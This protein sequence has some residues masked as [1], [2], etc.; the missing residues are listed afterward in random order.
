MRPGAVMWGLATLVAAA[1]CSSPTAPTADAGILD[2]TRVTYSA[3]IGSGAA[4][5]RAF[6]AR[7]AGT[8]TATVN[9]ITPATA[10]GIG[11]GIPRADGAGCLLSRSGIASDEVTA[12][13][14]AAVGVGLFCVQVFAPAGAAD[15]VHYSVT[16]DHP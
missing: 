5:S 10:L 2:P 15:V 9:G 14:S 3:I 6:T 11:L 12:T 7:V 16:L 1:S 8:A 4:S 13:V